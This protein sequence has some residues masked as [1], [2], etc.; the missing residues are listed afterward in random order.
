MLCDVMFSFFTLNAS[1]FDFSAEWQTGK[2]KLDRSVG[3]LEGVREI[4]AL[5]AALSQ[6]SGGGG[7]R[8]KAKALTPQKTFFIPKPRDAL[9]PALVGPTHHSMG[10][11]ESF[12]CC[13]IPSLDLP[14]FCLS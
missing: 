8:G 4:L 5:V 11:A 2:I 3:P 12:W 1:I 13:W 9:H 14:P 10:Q 7:G 6:N